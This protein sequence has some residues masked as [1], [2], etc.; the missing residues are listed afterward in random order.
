MNNDS[1]PEMS[2]I[3]TA[4]ENYQSIETTIQYLLE[5]TVRDR[6]ELVIVTQSAERLY[7]NESL[8]NEFWG[9]QVV[10]VGQIRSIGRA[11][12]EGIRQ[13]H[14]E[15]VALTEDHCFPEPGWAAAL[16]EAHS[17]SWAAVGP[18][19]RNANP[20]TMVSWCDFLIGYC[21]W[22]EPIAAAQMSFLPGH[23]S[24]Y[25]RSVLTEEY[26]DQLDNMMESETVMHFD[27]CRKGY[28]LYIE[29]AACS[30]HV[31]F[32]LLSSWLPVQYF[33]GRSFAGNRI[34]NWSVLKRLLYGIASPLIPIVRLLRINRELRRPGRPRYLLVRLLPL[35]VL[36]LLFDGLGQMIGYLMG[37]GNATDKLS[38]FEFNRIKHITK[39]DRRSLFMPKS[40]KA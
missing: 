19:I 10:S 21:F 28:R 14:G 35:L 16:I 2:V 11:N 22:M 36:G 34:H 25:K 9:Y 38:Q 27:L 12:A 7:F 31:N 23:N 40:K 3:I 6:I 33:A 4:L 26:G 17:D 8:L 39:N 29:P 20:D 18:V 37:L 24:S 32:S 5:Q 30:E 13:A 15:L 1:G